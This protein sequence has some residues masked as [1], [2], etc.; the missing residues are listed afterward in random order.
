M[1]KKYVYLFSEGDG[2][3]KELL[4]GKGANL[5]EMTRMGMPVPQG[6]TVSTEA[7][8]RYYDDGKVI[9]EDILA[10]IKWALAE[11]EKLNGKKFGD[12]GNP[13]LVSVRSGARASMPGMMDTILNLGLN[14]AVAAGMIA[15]N[16]DPAFARFVYDSYRRFIQMF[17]DV[18]M[19]VS[20]KEFEEIIDE[21]KEKKG[22]RDDIDLDL[23][24]MKELV[25]RFKAYYKKQ[26]GGEFPTDPKAQLLEAVKAVFRSWD[27]PRANVY[28]HM[29]EIPYSWGSA[30]NVQPMVYGNLNNDSGTGVAFTRDPA[31]G[32]KALFGEYL[33]NAQGEDVV[34]GVRTPNK[35]AQLEQDMP[36]VYEQFVAIVNKLEQYYKDMQDME[37]TIENRKLYML[38]TRNGKRTAAAALKIALDLLDEGIIAESDIP[39]RLEWGQIERIITENRM[40]VTGFPLIGVGLAASS[41]FAT[42]KAVYNA[43]EAEQCIE[44]RERFIYCRVEMS[45]NDLEIMCSDYCQGVVT[46]RGG[47]SSHAAV[48]CRG[49]RKPAVSGAGDFV[50][51]QDIY[52][53]I[54]GNT[55]RIYAGIGRVLQNESPDIAT[56]Y[57]ILKNIIRENDGCEVTAPLV[58]RLWNIIVLGKRYGGKNNDKRFV[59]CDSDD[60][61]SF[62]Q[63]SEAEKDQMLCVAS[64]LKNGAIIV[65]DLIDFLLTQLSSQVPLGQHYQYVRPLLDPAKAIRRTQRNGQ[66]IQLT[67]LEF[68]DICKYISFLYD[69]RSVKIYFTTTVY[70]DGGT[71]TWE[72]LNCLDYTNPLAESLIINNC[73]AESAAVYINDEP[74]PNEQLTMLYHSMRRRAYHKSGSKKTS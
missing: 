69:I 53:T 12:P 2:S 8:T 44:D 36:E 20:K 64:E 22:V 49:M 27:N 55:G 68:F 56:L 29:N 26:K 23:G 24:D 48:V 62:T 50:K 19:D 15:G 14:D 21:L 1:A 72:P 42:G 35:I 45:P 17:G 65:E 52:I 9:G 58:W 70:D 51:T 31:T 32:E 74:I 59:E 39:L 33:I 41:G 4:G 3:M 28:R 6:F 40:N 47:M 73:Y 5:A 57:A 10:Q 16:P 67:A 63:P 61:V 60:Y 54:D 7:C 18:V 37:F 13:L 38:C 43:S 46:Q 25:V 34:A 11:T 66:A 30:V 71:N